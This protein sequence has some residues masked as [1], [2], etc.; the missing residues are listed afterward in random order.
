MN[1]KVFLKELRD[2]NMPYFKK[3]LIGFFYP[4]DR[5]T[6]FEV[7]INFTL[8]VNSM[9]NLISYCRKKG[10]DLTFEYNKIWIIEF[11]R[12]TK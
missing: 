4:L 12:K 10:Y 11:K 2:L 1:K 6:N 5:E 7:A 8:P 9:N 3:E